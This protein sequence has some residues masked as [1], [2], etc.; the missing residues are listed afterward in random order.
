MDAPS[1]MHR[2]NL[3]VSVC[4]PV[5]LVHG[6]LTQFTLAA[7]IYQLSMMFQIVRY[8]NWI[9]EHKIEPII[10]R[11]GDVYLWDRHPCPP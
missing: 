2:T 1:V 3:F 7:W 11:K 8:W 9:V 4:I 6:V 10:G 5:L